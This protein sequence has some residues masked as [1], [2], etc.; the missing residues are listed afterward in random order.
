MKKLAVVL[1]LVVTLLWSAPRLSADQI[2]VAHLNGK[3]VVSPPSTSLATGIATVDLNSLQTMITVNLSFSGLEGP[4]TA[5][6]IHGPALPGA[7]AGILF[8][9]TGVPSAI[10]GSIPTQSF[11]ITSTD[12]GYL[13]SGL[14]YVNVHTGVFPAGEIRGQLSAVPEPASLLLTAIGL[15]F[16]AL[17]LSRRKHAMEMPQSR[18]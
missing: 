15:G 11:A 9:L 13:E 2:F 8:P 18:T 4:A 7:N 5:A 1:G 14:L 10:S 17:L 12:L 3:Q 16:V 6:H